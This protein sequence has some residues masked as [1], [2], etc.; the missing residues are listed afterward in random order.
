MVRGHHA[1]VV[2]EAVGEYLKWSLYSHT[3]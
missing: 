1:A 3:A 2:N